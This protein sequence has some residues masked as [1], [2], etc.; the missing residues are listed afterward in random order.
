MR[1]P[2]MW[3]AQRLCRKFPVFQG[4]HWQQLLQPSLILLEVLEARLL[5]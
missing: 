3:A 2:T 4:L 1:S 5:Q